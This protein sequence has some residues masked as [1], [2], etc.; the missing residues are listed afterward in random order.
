[1]ETLRFTLITDG[2]SDRTLLNIIK[3]LLNDIYPELPTI[4]TFADFGRLR[5]PP[6]T[7]E[8]LERIKKAEEYYPFDILFYH[9]DAESSADGIYEQRCEEI[10]SVLDESTLSTTICVVPVVMMESWLIID[11]EAIKKAAGNRNYKGDID[12]PAINRIEK[13]RSPKALLHDTLKQVSGL[14]GRNLRKF[15]PH[16]HVH[17]VSENIS[18]YSALRQLSSFKQ[19]EAK[20][21]EVIDALMN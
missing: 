1:M 8:V 5:N 17:L 10:L 3:W 21:K 11:R 9:R 12:L 19:L 2:T 7:N 20:A 15:D 16:S 4:G 6:K 18:D 13:H 14:R